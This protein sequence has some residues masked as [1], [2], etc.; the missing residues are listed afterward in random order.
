MTSRSAAISERRAARERRREELAREREQILAQEEEER[1]KVERATKEALIQKRREER[2]LAKQKEMERL[3][4]QEHLAELNSRAT[5]HYRTTLLRKRGVAP[6]WGFIER[7]R[8]DRVAAD[9]VSVQLLLRRCL[10][11]WRGRWSQVVAEKERK[12][13]KLHESI[14]IRGTWKAWRKVSI[15]KERHIA[16]TLITEQGAI[17]IEDHTIVSVSLSV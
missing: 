14:L 8:A 12:A 3:R 16:Y 1:R 4:R 5:S 6:W 2:R 9:R 13:K 11:D 10:R 7:C 17:M 15:W